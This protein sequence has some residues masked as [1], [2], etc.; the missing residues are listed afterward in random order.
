MAPPSNWP[1]KLSYLEFIIL[2]SMLMALT[3][4]SIDAMLPANPQLTEQFGIS[5]PKQLQLMVNI[6]F[7][8][9][10]LSQLICGPIADCYGRKPVLLTGIGIFICASVYAVFSSSYCA[11]IIARFFQGI[12]SGAPRVIP[13]SII[14]DLTEGRQMAKLISLTMMIFIIVPVLA[15]SIGEVILIFASWHWIFVMLV[16]MALILALWLFMRLPETL[17]E[18]DR[19]SLSLSNIF[20]NMKTVLTHPATMGYTL[21]LS[22]IFGAFNI[23]LSASQPI[24][25]Q[26][27]G[28]ADQFALIFG[29]VAIFMGFASYLNAKLVIKLGMRK[30]SQVGLILFIGLSIA[31]V[32]FCLGNNGLPSAAIFIGLMAALLFLIGLIFPNQ[33]ALAMEPMG[34]LAGTAASV[35]GCIS[36]VIGVILGTIA[37]YWLNGSLTPMALAFLA[38]GLVSICIANF[39]DKLSATR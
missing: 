28:L 36:T 35:I 10:A 33:H 38:Y 15:P 32:L 4:L 19:Q 17:A 22:F 13:T 21:A 3:A 25:D 5:Q 37:G 27:Y 1:L 8:G 14:R 20:T 12:G 29:F 18:S 16:I 26:Y 6:Y 2:I 34:K 30:L 11:L 9:F 39:T 31:F 23:Y 24:F 7:L